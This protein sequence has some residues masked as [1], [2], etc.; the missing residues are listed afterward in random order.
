MSAFMRMAAPRFRFPL[1]YHC[2]TGTQ[3]LLIPSLQKINLTL[4]VY[5]DNRRVYLAHGSLPASTC[6]DPDP[7]YTKAMPTL[8]TAREKPARAERCDQGRDASGL[9]PFA[10]G[11]SGSPGCLPEAG[12]VYHKAQDAA[13][14][15]DCCWPF[16][17]ATA[18]SQLELD[19]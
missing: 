16:P 6:I 15:L 11:T 8:G 1:D 2:A 14:S 10:K 18:M 4:T 17:T 9:R 19:S 3:R 12:S 13:N 5:L 7:R